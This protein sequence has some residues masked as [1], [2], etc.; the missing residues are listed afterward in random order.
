[1]RSIEKIGL[2]IGVL[3]IAKYIAD[4]VARNNYFLIIAIFVAF[5]YIVYS[6][7]NN[8]FTLLSISAFIPFII[9]GGSLFAIGGR[10]IELLAPVFT[11]LLLF[12]IYSQKRSMFPRKA[13]LF[14]IAVAVIGIWCIMNYIKNPVS[15]SSL[16]VDYKGGGIRSYYIIVIGMTTFLFSLWFFTYKEIKVQKWLW[17]LIVSC[18]I[19]GDLRIIAYSQDYEMPFLGAIFNYTWYRSGQSQIVISGLREMAALG[20]PLI[21]SILHIGK[22]NIYSSLALINIIAFMI[23]GGGKSNFVAILFAVGSYIILFHRKYLLPAILLPLILL[24]IVYFAD[25]SV[26]KLKFSRA[27]DLGGGIEQQSSDRYYT[28]IY[29][30][31]IIKDNPVFGK[32]IGHIDVNLRDIE[33]GRLNTASEKL[34]TKIIEGRVSGIGGH[35]AYF[36]MISVFGV[37]G[38]FFL[39]VMLF[40]GIYYAYRIIRE[41]DELSDDAQLALFAFTFLLI[42]AL[43]F[44]AGGNGYDSYELWFFAGMIAGLKAKERVKN[45]T[46]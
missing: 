8:K 19:I 18:L 7:W 41:R 14:I 32:G 9:P 25:L 33:A 30:W 16:G 39:A 35:G 3:F 46:V 42:L 26:S 28:F 36:S 10:W 13:A 27:L 6:S 15:G 45:V 40:G 43:T 12:E 34:L 11:V 31:K 5:F 23:L 22:L 2:F 4:Q 29:M 21:I 1:M 37:G 24:S 44:V 20:I 38:I 17:I